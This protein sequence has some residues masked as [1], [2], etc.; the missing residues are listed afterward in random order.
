MAFRPLA[1]LRPSR[2]V[3]LICALLPVAALAQP[4]MVDQGKDWTDTARQ[5]FYT[6]DQGSRVIP[7][8]WIL[9]LKAPD[10]SG[11][12]DDALARYGYLPMPDRAQANIPVGFTVTEVDGIPQLGMTCSACHTRQIEVDGTEYRID[13]G[14]AIVDFQAFLTDLDTAMLNVLADTDATEDFEQAVLGADAAAAD[15]DDLTSQ[16]Q[17]WSKRLHVLLEG[18]L[19]Q[20]GWGPARLD[21]VTMIFNRL[22]G[23]DLGKPEDD[24]I[25][26]ENIQPAIAPTRYPFLWNAGKQDY[27]Q[28]PGFAANG[29]EILALSRN[30]G[31][32]Y[33]VFG[34]FHPKEQTGL[35][36]LNRDY[37]AGNSANFDGL[38]TQEDNLNKIGPPKW[39]WDLDEALVA[40]G[41]DVF[42]LSNDEGG[43]VACHGI[44][45]GEF[46]S[47]THDTW[48]TPRLDVGTD[49]AE[50]KI[51]TNTARTGV[52]EGASIPIITGGKLGATEPAVK[53]LATS[54]V[55]SIIQWGLGDRSDAEVTELMA[56]VDPEQELPPE[57]QNLR[58][59]FPTEEDLAARATSGDDSAKCV[60][61]SRV[62]Q[63]I[64]AAAPY[65]HNGS[66][67]TLADL[68]KP[69]SARPASF[70]PGPL[71]DTKNVGMALK[72]T[73]F[74]FTI[75]T[76]DCSDLMSG[77][78]RC[79][80]EFGTDL[81]DADKA[82]LLEYLKSL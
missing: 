80:H 67:P 41:K 2:L 65:L 19:T 1:L 22:T 9:A 30:L 63:G 77:N 33:G 11:F 74:D 44:K 27:T 79:G 12:M 34:V 15:G 69:A 53:L 4:T 5:S 37:M 32:V 28:W 81:S 70:M 14:P 61:E 18:S 42:N 47:F 50:C 25:I 13:G 8:D 52:L 36:K 16:M 20:P 55:G 3:P 51:M 75:E 71:Y 43:C 82:A 38:L 57:F 7:L 73:A 72:Q 39:Q 21:A 66:V 23:L 58:K 64:W 68:L 56:R 35:F 24:Y 45:K 46:R 54:V 26:A 6:Q 10:G 78:S 76:T 17:V 29:D 60:Y 31:E 48:A 49:R 62:L 59:A 40:R